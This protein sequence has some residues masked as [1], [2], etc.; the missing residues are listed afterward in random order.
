MSIEILPSQNKRNLTIIREKEEEFRSD[1]NDSGREGIDLR[2][3][4]V[5]DKVTIM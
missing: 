4:V 3:Y 1:I 2:K 5:V